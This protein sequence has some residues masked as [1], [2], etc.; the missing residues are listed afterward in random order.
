[1]CQRRRDD[2]MALS[3]RKQHCRQ[4]EEEET[5][6]IVNVSDSRLGHLDRDSF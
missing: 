3:A 5:G 4:Y 1:V 2:V 6:Q